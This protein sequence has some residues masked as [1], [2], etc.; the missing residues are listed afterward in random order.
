[1]VVDENNDDEVLGNNDNDYSQRSSFVAWKDVNNVDKVYAADP[2]FLFEKMRTEMIMLTSESIA[3][4]PTLLF[5]NMKT[6]LTILTRVQSIWYFTVFG[7][8]EYLVF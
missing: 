1:M 3:G 4:N 8:S 5:Q 7:I 6:I 2:A